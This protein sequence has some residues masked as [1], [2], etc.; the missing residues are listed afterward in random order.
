MSNVEGWTDARY[1]SFIRSALRRAWNKYPPKY[2]ALNNAKR[3][4]Q[5]AKGNQ[6]YEYQC[7][8][9]KRWYARKNVSVDHISPAGT[10]RDYSDLP[11]FV[12]KLLCS[13]EGLQVLCFRCHQ[14]KTNEERGIIPEVAE[15]KK[16]K[17]E[18]QKKYLKKKGLP[19]GSNAAKRIEILEGYINAK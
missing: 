16:M 9:C 19:E 8:S 14:K 4:K 15:F 11:A 6:K 13:V 2:Q 17:A 3:R 7:A 1:W 12:S 5:Q 18:E 10:L